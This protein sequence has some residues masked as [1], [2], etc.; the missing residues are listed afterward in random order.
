M[1]PLSINENAKN[2]V[3]GGHPKIDAR[4]NDVG[5]I[6]LALFILWNLL[7]GRFQMYNAILS[8]FRNLC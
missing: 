6:L 5:I 2:T 4:Q 3:L 7:P 1:G 8:T